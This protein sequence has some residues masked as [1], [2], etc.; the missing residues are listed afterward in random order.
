MTTYQSYQQ[1]KPIYRILFVC[2][3]NIC[4]S[5]AAEGILTCWAKT[6]P[7]ADSWKYD[8]EVDSAGTGGWHAGELADQRMRQAAEKRG[9]PLTHRAR[10]ITLQ[11]FT[12][13]DFLF[14]MDPSIQKAVLSLSP[15]QVWTKKVR[16]FGELLGDGEI[17]VPDPYFG[18]Q[19]GF[20]EVLDLLERGLRHLPAFLQRE[21][22]KS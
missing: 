14:T 3:G 10:Q 2:L 22:E 4:R 6:L 13:F 18:N 15:D 9:Y 20:D 21:S 7:E 5:P 11:D 12:D 19:K 16:P 8:L 17:A 1:K